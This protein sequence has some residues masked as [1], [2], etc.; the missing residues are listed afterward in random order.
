MSLFDRPA[1]SGRPS[2]RV[3]LGGATIVAGA[4]LLSGCQFRPLYGVSP[5]L[6]A[7]GTEQTQ[8]VQA[9]MAAIS[10]K[11]P[12]YGDSGSIKRINQVLRNQLI[13]AFTRGGDALPPKY[14]L[15]ILTD[16]RRAEVG[17]EQLADVPTAYNITVN[18]SFVLADIQ[19]D[20]TLY[21][22]RSFASASFDFSS[23]R[24]ANL[25]AERDAEDR[26][27]KVVAADI[28][29]RIAS[30][31]ATHPVEPAEPVE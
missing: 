28:N 5:T 22:G 15:E 2:R 9:Q 17:V 24:F 31:F 12:G 25:R 21:T 7:D 30:F 26:A 23:Q 29:T 18:A 11:F 16:K 3:L 14:R 10:M 19:T 4:L 6:L 20:R 8:T 1:K 27:A 13:F